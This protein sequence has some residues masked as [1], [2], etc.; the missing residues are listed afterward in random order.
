[1]DKEINLPSEIKYYI[2]LTCGRYERFVL[3]LACRDYYFLYKKYFNESTKFL[4]KY[5]AKENYLSLYIWARSYNFNNHIT[6]LIEALDSKKIDA[7][8]VFI[9]LQCNVKNHLKIIKFSSKIYI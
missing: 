3:S 4:C 6:D 8:L 7:K 9:A 5:A 2:L 1:M